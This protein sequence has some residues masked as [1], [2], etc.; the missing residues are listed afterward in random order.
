M[1][2]RKQYELLLYINHHFREV[3]IPPSYDEMRDALDLRSKSGIH[4]L[5][6]ALEERGF[7][8]RMKNR[9]RALEII[10][11]PQSLSPSLARIDRQREG[12]SIIEGGLGKSHIQDIH[13]E[14][15]DI[16]HDA[17]PS[18]GIAYVPVMGCIAAGTPIEALENHINT[19]SVPVEMME[20]GSHYA[21]EVKGDS[22]IEAGI[23]SGDTVLIKSTNE[24][25]N[26]SI[27]VAL[28]DGY[29]ATLKRY[30]KRGKMIALEPANKNYEPRL[31]REEQVFIQGRMVGL[32]RNY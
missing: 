8:K 28:I 12:L 15:E 4:R 11:F 2:T 13:L 1:L 18:E 21:L 6:N 30:R 22:M 31:F 25:V 19:I 23:L 32:L 7:V 20:K 24:A 14:E 3:G 9:A 26:G 29:E 5:V 10:R 27:V 16:L 17:H